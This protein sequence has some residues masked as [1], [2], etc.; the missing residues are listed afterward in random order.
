MVREVNPR[1]VII[2]LGVSA[3]GC[4]DAPRDRWRQDSKEL[5]RRESEYVE[6]QVRHAGM[7]EA[8][9]KRQFGLQVSIEKTLG[10]E[11][12]EITRD[13]LSEKINTSP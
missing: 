6:F 10:R 12:V 7:S 3:L 1:I 9:A 2:A 13:E 5:Q 4:N 11:P 8:E